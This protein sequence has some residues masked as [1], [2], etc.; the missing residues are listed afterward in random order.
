VRATVR[1]HEYPDGSLAIFKGP[2]RLA[3][4][5]PAAP[6]EDLAGTPVWNRSRWTDHDSGRRCRRLRAEVEWVVRDEPELRIVDQA[7][8]ECVKE[9]Q[10]TTKRRQRC[11]HRA[12]P[13]RG[14][15]FPF[16]GLLK[17]GRCGSNFTMVDGYRYGCATNRNCGEAACANDVRVARRIVKTRLLD[18]IVHGLFDAD[19][20]ARFQDALRQ[21]LAAADDLDAQRRELISE[22]RRSDRQARNLIE[23]LKEGVAIQMIRDELARCEWQQ[24]ETKR[25]LAALARADQAG[26]TIP[27]RLDGYAAALV[28]LPGWSSR[29]R[30]PPASRSA[31]SSARSGCCPTKAT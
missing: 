30:T 3:S 15:K 31:R 28:G 1:A 2:W 13:G 9:R 24:V 20:V 29:T 5:P 10:A 14:P 22:L 4:F 16:S 6:A 25:R 18:A 26:V 11:H 8:W 21:R 17:C 23:A 7:L 12:G 27:G 19:E